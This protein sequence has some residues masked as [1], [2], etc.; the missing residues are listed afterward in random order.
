MMTPLDLSTRFYPVSISNPHICLA[1]T[2]NYYEQATEALKK[3]LN[4]FSAERCNKVFNLQQGQDVTGKG[5]K[6][7]P[8]ALPESVTSRHKSHMAASKYQYRLFIIIT[9]YFKLLMILLLSHQFIIKPLGLE[10][11][12]VY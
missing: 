6:G 3:V 1:C 4:P 5:P 10:C 8:P 9:I 11:T 7:K 2:K 12:S